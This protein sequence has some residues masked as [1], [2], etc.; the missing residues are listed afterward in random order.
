[1]FAIHSRESRIRRADFT[2]IDGDSTGTVRGTGGVDAKY[3]W[4]EIAAAVGAQNLKGEV[5]LMLKY[6]V[7]VDGRLHGEKYYQT[8][9]EKIPDDSTRLPL[10][11]S[12]GPGASHQQCVRLQARRQAGFRAAGYDDACRLLGVDG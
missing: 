6:A 1:M 9:R 4:G 2:P 3:P 7:S 11:A 12:G 5:D 10:E 8:V